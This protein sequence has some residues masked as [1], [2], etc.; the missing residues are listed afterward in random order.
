MVICGYTLIYVVILVTDDYEY[1]LLYM[2]YTV[3]L[4]YAWLF[5]VVHGYM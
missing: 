3:I 4:S 5:M 1:I 2:V